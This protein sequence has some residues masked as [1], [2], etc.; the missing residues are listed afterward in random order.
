MLN[1]YLRETDTVCAFF[2]WNLTLCL[3][4]VAMLVKLVS[5]E[6][7]WTSLSL[8]S[9]F[10]ICT[11][12]WTY[13]FIY[14]RGAMLFSDRMIWLRRPHFSFSVKVIISTYDLHCMLPISSSSEVCD[15][16]QCLTITFGLCMLS[17]KWKRSPS[18]EHYVTSRKGLDH[19]V[20]HFSQCRHTQP[21]EVFNCCGLLRN[22]DHMR[23]VF[24]N[25]T[26]GLCNAG[27]LH[28]SCY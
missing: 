16:K 3:N 7:I 4:I 5:S 28:K 24:Q 19:K 21:S 17:Y 6:R 22:C 25:W 9:D 26:T 13:V 18:W 27:I 20:K 12:S 23:L 15:W 8:F 1:L 11:C 10:S 2:K 14:E